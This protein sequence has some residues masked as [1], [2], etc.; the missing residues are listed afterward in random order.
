MLVCTTNIKLKE[1]PKTLVIDVLRL[2][3]NQQC[4]VKPAH[5]LDVFAAG[6]DGLASITRK[7]LPGPEA[8]FGK[9]PF[10]VFDCQRVSEAQS[11]HI[12]ERGK[13]ILAANITPP[14]SSQIILEGVLFETLLLRGLRQLFGAPLNEKTIVDACGALFGPNKRVNDGCIEMPGVS[15]DQLARQ[16]G[17]PVSWRRTDNHEA[18]LRRLWW[19]KSRQIFKFLVS[20]YEIDFA[21]D[22]NCHTNIPRPLI[23]PS[24]TN[25]FAKRHA[26]MTGRT[27]WGGAHDAFH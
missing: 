10:G 5:K 21:G 14:L 16:A 6:R 11:G 19:E 20:I 15:T 27:S 7:K 9:E 4:W 12:T 2:T 13:R 8:P 26:L 1:Y 24:I 25:S 3:D 18:G 22:Y 23:Y 17:F